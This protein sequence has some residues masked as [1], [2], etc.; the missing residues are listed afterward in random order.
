VL[1]Q[2]DKQASYEGVRWGNRGMPKPFLSSMFRSLDG[3]EWRHT[4]VCSTTASC[5]ALTG[6]AGI[7]W[8]AWDLGSTV[9]DPGEK[10][11]VQGNY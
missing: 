3:K 1:S 4:P 11:G 10:F 9:M 8:K 6:L 7:P 5:E 2:P